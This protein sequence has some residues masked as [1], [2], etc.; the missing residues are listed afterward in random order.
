MGA[1]PAGRVPGALV[2]GRASAATLSGLA[3]I[4]SAGTR[5]IVRHTWI[6]SVPLFLH[7]TLKLRYRRS[8]FD[9]FS[10]HFYDGFTVA[11][12]AKQRT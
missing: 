6:L 2:A 11:H 10:F 7:L 9:E 5:G 1:L 4:D 12:S 3:P 8:H